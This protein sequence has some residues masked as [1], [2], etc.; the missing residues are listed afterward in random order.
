M[1]FWHDERVAGIHRLDVEERERMFIFVH[2]VG[3]KLTADY[4]AE[5]AVAHAG[6]IQYDHVRPG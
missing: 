3:G 5:N 1:F 2:F 6:S 4:F